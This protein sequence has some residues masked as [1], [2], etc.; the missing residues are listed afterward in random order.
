MDGIQRSFA[1]SGSGRLN[2]GQENLN[3]RGRNGVTDYRITRFF[4]GSN[5]GLENMYIRNKNEK[6][7]RAECIIMYM[8]IANREVLK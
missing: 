3:Q 2:S 1:D 6:T 7:I 4:C 8:V 5:R